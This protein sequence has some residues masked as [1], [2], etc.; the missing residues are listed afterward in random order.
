M[1]ESLS[2]LISAISQFK[3]EPSPCPGI[4]QVFH[5]KRP[6]NPRSGRFVLEGG[7]GSYTEYYVLMSEKSYQGGRAGT[8]L[9]RHISMIE[10]ADVDAEDALEK[11]IDLAEATQWLNEGS[12]A[13]A[14][15]NT[16]AAD[17]KLSAALE[18][19]RKFPRRAE[20]PVVLSKLGN[21]RLRQQRTE[22]SRSYYSQSVDEASRIFGSDDP[23]TLKSEQALAMVEINLG[24]I[25]IATNRLNRVVRVVKSMHRRN[26][27]ENISSQVLI[28]SYCSLGDI[29]LEKGD[30]KG[31][32]V[33]YE[34]ALDKAEQ[35]FGQGHP[36]TNMVSGKIQNLAAYIQINGIDHPHH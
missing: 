21:V 17:T 35:L 2:D 4:G 18:T 29:K 8:R 14:E 28:M 33:E 3:A 13:E 7:V 20:L 30:V 23:F 32:M 27:F 34:K 25:Q 11:L 10:P 24:H 26:D 22:E 6:E 16:R 15:G 9:I 5:D 1:Q 36:A 31:V 12:E 19:F